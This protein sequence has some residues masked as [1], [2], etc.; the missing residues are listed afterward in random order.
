M[1]HESRACETLRSVPDG[2]LSLVVVEDGLPS[3]SYCSW[4]CVERQRLAAMTPHPP[5]PGGS[6][7]PRPKAWVAA[8]R[9]EVSTDGG[10]EQCTT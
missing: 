5:G 8:A 9:P 10:E 4:C 3:L 1:A 6:R 2:A 7:F